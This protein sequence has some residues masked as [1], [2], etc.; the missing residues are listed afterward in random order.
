MPQ[1]N[2]LE[3]APP[4]LIVAIAVRFLL[5]LALLAAAGFVG[6]NLTSGTWRWVAAPAAVVGVI[7]VWALFVA[8]KARFKLS[9]ESVRAVEATLFLTVAAGL[10][11]LG[12]GTVAA[13]GLIIWGVDQVAIMLFRPR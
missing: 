9:R 13:Y 5:E 11:H 10:M 8:P 3:G 1:R 7:T 6:W 4:A 12:Y 2:P